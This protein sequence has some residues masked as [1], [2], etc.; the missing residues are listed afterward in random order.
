[1]TRRLPPAIACLLLACAMCLMG[2]A[3][4][5]AAPA[6]AAAPASTTQPV[7]SAPPAKR[8]APPGQPPKL[9]KELAIKSQISVY[10]ELHSYLMSG[11]RGLGKV[12]PEY[13]AELES[14]QLADS[15]IREPRVWQ[16]INDA[17][18]EGPDMPAIQKAGEKIVSQFVFGDHDG[19]ALI[20]KSLASAWPRWEAKEMIQYRIGLQELWINIM[21]K[22]FEDVVAPRVLP[23]LYEKMGFAPLDA[24]ITLYPV[25]S[26]YQQG[27]WGRTLQGYYMLIPAARRPEFVVVE[28]ILHEMTHV[29][30][31]CQKDPSGTL[32]ARLRRKA[33]TAD[34]KVLEGFTHG[35]VV[36]NAGEM[37]RRYVR[38]EYKPYTMLSFDSKEQIDKYRTVFAAAWNDYLDG[39]TKADATVAAL[40]AVLTPPPTSAA[41]PKAGALPKAS[42]L[43]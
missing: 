30:E 17:L 4:L 3:A 41:L 20:F 37:L 32:L 14:Y 6:A 43:P 29:I 12:A 33:A 7:P 18:V 10:L 27:A 28:N 8:P 38:E 25:I 11:A 9:P 31:A 21:Q 23:Q 16:L 2:P 35:L 22:K 40:A 34:A 15:T 24:P 19:A 26:G 39:K 5:A 1:M 42:A 36:W 13:Q